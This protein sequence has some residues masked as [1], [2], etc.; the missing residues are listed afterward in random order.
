ME[1]SVLK[2]IKD[3]LLQYFLEKAFPLLY[4]FLQ[5]TCFSLHETI[6]ILEVESNRTNFELIFIKFFEFFSPFK[7]TELQIFESNQMNFEQIPI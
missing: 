5:N 2:Q 1:K 7:S 4:L 3:M 6:P